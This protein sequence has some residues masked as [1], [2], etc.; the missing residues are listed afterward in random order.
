MKTPMKQKEKKRERELETANE[1][2]QT[3]GCWEV[4]SGK[5]NECIVCT[6]FA[7]KY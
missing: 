4:S 7:L 6:N 3:N 1:K 5:V 2:D